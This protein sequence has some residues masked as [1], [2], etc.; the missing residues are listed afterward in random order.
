MHDYRV[1]LL[2][3]QR[4][5]VW[6]RWVHCDDLDQAVVQV[7]SEMPDTACEIWDGPRLLATFEPKMAA[8]ADQNTS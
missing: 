7:S 6:A 8:K 2:D 4:K 1:Y 3:G 5:I